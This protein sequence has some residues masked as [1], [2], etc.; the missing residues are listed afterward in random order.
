MN[1]IGISEGFHDAAL[2]LLQN[3]KILYASQSERYSKVKN[4]PWVHPDQWPKADRYQPNIVAYY[5]KPF[6]KNLRRLY[7]GQSWQKPRVNYDYSFGHHESHAAAGYYTSPF[8]EC[9]ILVIDAIG[10]W[11]TISVW[12]A[13]NNLMDKVYSRKYPYSLGLLYSAITQRI[14][15]KPNEDEYITMGMSAFGN[16]KYD[17]EYLLWENNHR[18]VGDIF[19]EASV[20][21]LAA[22]VQVLYERE[23]LKLIEMCPHENLVLMGG[24][25]LNCAAN[26]K[27][28]GK[29]IWI[30]PAPGDAGSAIG[31][32][33]LVLK[34]KLKWRSPYLGYPILQ[35]VPVKSVVKELLDN[36]VCGIA[37]GKAE[38]GP[39]ALG[40]RSLLG[41]PRFDIKDTVNQIKRRQLFRPF[42][43][44]ILE[45]F[46]DEYFEGPMNEYM[47]F[48]A[49]AK[50]DYSSVTHVDGTARVQVVTKD[51]GSN[52]RLILEEFYEQT[53]CP[54][55]LNTSL[56]IKGQ[57]MVNTWEDAEEWS[58]KYNVA[59]F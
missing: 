41:D 51:C 26:S 48:V 31:A 44:A 57:P 30:M 23:L 4:D 29:N 21:D 7:A 3:S 20:E 25:A 18:G 38:F 10:E 9:N 54:M 39:R 42:A 15:L 40:N 22:S 58:K 34:K 13:K 49:K 45:E 50:H 33:A 1:I 6:R 47:Q 32:A 46:K 56:N 8:D 17:L 59:I 11:D 53:G 14:G 36:K 2:C 55:L 37:N 5:E 28:K 27:I 12:K 52:L 43:P 19:P 35:G 16:P 24:C